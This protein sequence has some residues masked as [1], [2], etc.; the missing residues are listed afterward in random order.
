MAEIENNGTNNNELPSLVLTKDDFSGHHNIN[1][2]Y[3]IKIENRIYDIYEKSKDFTFSK[4]IFDLSQQ[5][6]KELLSKLKE[7]NIKPTD[8][9]KIE[10]K[11][12][13][14]IYVDYTKDGEA[15]QLLFDLMDEQQFFK[16]DQ[17]QQKEQKERELSNTIKYLE[18]SDKILQAMEYIFDKNGKEFFWEID[19][20][21]IVDTDK[22]WKEFL[23]KDLKFLKNI[24]DTLLKR[25]DS[26]NFNEL[27]ENV[28]NDIL[29]KKQ[30]YLEIVMWIWD[31]YEWSAKYL[32][33]SDESFDILTSSLVNGFPINKVLDLLSELHKKI[34]ANN[35]QST[36]VERSY[37]LTM[38]TLHESV[39][40]RLKKE[41]APNEDFLRYAKIITWRWAYTWGTLSQYE[42]VDI[43]DNLRD[44]NNANEAILYVMNKKGWI[45][46][47]IKK[48]K[49]INIIDKKV[50]NLKPK[51]IL[52]DFQKIVN[53]KFWNQPQ[54]RKKM[55]Q[56]WYWDIYNI[57][58]QNYSDLDYEQ[59]L[60]ISV[61]FRMIEKLKI[62]KWI[63]TKVLEN[64]EK[65]LVA[66]FWEMTWEDYTYGALSWL[67][68][69]V[70]IDY[71][72]E[73]V[74]NMEESLFSDW[75]NADY[76]C[77]DW[78]DKDVLQIFMDINWSWG[79][80]DIS[81]A[82]IAKWKTAWKVVWI[83]W[84]AALAP[85]AIMAGTAV[86]WVA[87]AWI[88]AQWAAAWAVASI[89][90]MVIN[91]KWYNTFWEAIVDIW[92]DLAIWTWTW[93]L[94][95]WLVKISWI[96]QAKLFSKDW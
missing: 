57:W 19:D 88:I 75:E 60:K 55:E 77:L 10:V 93:A 66:E 95:W 35:Y 48:D 3:D 4:D 58:D 78:I 18:K 54:L 28:R 17:A 79:F 87:S 1:E 16:W 61:L 25:I 83:M 26:A 64:W 43:D 85:F 68:K 82:N 9:Q 73:T 30:K 24:F 50:E 44:Q 86:A 29:N 38:E 5:K 51:S 20:R 42:D 23:W 65:V 84:I 13:W 91:P 21:D 2:D 52:E 11:P 63:P 15:K 49:K 6:T 71:Q 8:L 33:K 37:K 45:L 39:L 7:L 69:E 96:E 92:T 70:A 59:Q 31:R 62:W 27:P 32:K 22:F 40:E 72:K 67:F 53:E 12:D 56:A 94:W 74:V 34:D 80:F 90:S 46:E 89:A 14:K 76:Y 36:D 47:K 41:N 81:D